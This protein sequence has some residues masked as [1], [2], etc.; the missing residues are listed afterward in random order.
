MLEITNSNVGFVPRKEAFTPYIDRSSLC[1]MY[2]RLDQLQ[3]EF[4]KDQIG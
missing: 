1:P 2:A 3:D 4:Q